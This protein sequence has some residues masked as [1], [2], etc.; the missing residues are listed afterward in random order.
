MLAEAVQAAVDT[1]QG[2]PDSTSPRN[3]GS[4]SRTPQQVVLRFS[5]LA[6]RNVQLAGDFNNWVP[7]QGIDTRIAEG[8]F[9]KVVKVLPG[10]YQY[11]II[12]DGVW[13]PDPGN[14]VRVPNVFGGTNSLLRVARGAHN[15]QAGRPA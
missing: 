12:V 3:R 5:E 7:D 8:V 9:E 4:Q 6:G 11:R 13:Q 1:L 2:R 14:P 15:S 10:S